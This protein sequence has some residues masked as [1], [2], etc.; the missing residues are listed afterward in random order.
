V[1]Y[2]HCLVPDLQKITGCCFY[3]GKMDRYEAEKLLEGKPEGK[4]SFYFV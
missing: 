4:Y 3:W 2:I 1:D